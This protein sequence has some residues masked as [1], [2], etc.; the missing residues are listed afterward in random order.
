MKIT[1][2]KLKEIIREELTRSWTNPDYDRGDYEKEIDVDKV[3]E[4]LSRLMYKKQSLGDKLGIN[5]DHIDLTSPMDVGEYNRQDP[6]GHLRKA[7]NG[8]QTQIRDVIDLLKNQE[9]PDEE[10]ESV[11]PAKS[12]MVRQSRTS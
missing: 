3:K 1:K 11:V 6:S 4:I 5:P 2:A 7:F 8:V 10:I 12:P 9:V